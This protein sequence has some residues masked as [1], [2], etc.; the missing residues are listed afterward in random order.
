[1]DY[2]AAITW[3][4][5]HDIRKDDGSYYEFGEVGDLVV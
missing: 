1:M 4:K 5:E 3:L 2:T